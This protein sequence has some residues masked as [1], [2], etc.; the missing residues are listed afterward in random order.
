MIYIC[1]IYY[2]KDLIFVGEEVHPWKLQREEEQEN[3]NLGSTVGNQVIQYF[4]P[5]PFPFFGKVDCL[6]F[7]SKLVTPD[8]RLQGCFILNNR[9]GD[10]AGKSSQLWVSPVDTCPVFDLIECMVLYLGFDLQQCVQR[11]LLF[12]LF[13]FFCCVCGLLCYTIA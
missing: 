7:S 5:I 3:I 10:F 13:E 11:P 9:T 8:P 1:M 12:F 6:Q 2:L 4:L